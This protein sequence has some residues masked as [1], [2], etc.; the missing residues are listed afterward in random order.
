[1]IT[2]DDL[3]L[4]VHL[5]D[6][7][8]HRVLE[9]LEL[10]LDGRGGLAELGVD[11][12]A[13]L[14]QGLDDD[15][16][17]DPALAAQGAQRAAGDAHLLGDQVRHV[18]DLGQHRT[19]LVATQRAGRQALRQLEQGHVRLADGGTGDLH[20]LVQRLGDFGQVGVGDAKLVRRQ[21]H[22]GV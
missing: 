7:L 17:G 16:G 18:R 15:V 6:E 5:S 20:R 14:E 19:H 2:R 21:G 4:L 8:E 1:L 10:P 13:R 9:R 22:A 3:E 12:P 11:L